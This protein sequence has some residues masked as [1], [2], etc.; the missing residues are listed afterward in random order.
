M[1]PIIL[2]SSSPRRQEI[3]KLLNIPFKVIIPNID[4]T[5]S[6]AIEPEEIPEFLARE[7]VTAVI[8]SLPPQQ[9]ILWI[10]GADTIILKEGKIFGKPDSRAQAEAFLREFSGKTHQVI[11]SVV[12]YNGRKK[13][14]VSK[15]AVTKVTFSELSDKEINW[16][17]DTEEWHGAAG[18]YRIQSLASCFIKSI[19][20][21][22]SCV[23]GLPIFELY[24]MFKEQG[25]SLLE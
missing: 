12:L 14:F 13:T 1:E 24:D 5:I 9:E 8:H 3:L 23:T 11:T 19:E 7:K 4:E 22:Q 6:S 25:Y 17:L 20:G 21:T 16:Y 2:A 10:L 15:N 18:G